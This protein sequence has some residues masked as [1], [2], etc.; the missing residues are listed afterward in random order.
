[1]SGTSVPLL[2]RDEPGR[3]QDDN[4]VAF[5][6]YHAIPAKFPEHPYDY[7]PHRPHGI[8]QLLLSDRDD[9]LGHR[10]TP[11]SRLRGEVEQMSLHTRLAYYRDLGIEHLGHACLVLR[12]CSDGRDGWLNAQQLPRAA[13]RPAGRHVR[14]LFETHDRLSELDS[15][16]ALLG[17]RLRVVDDAVVTQDTRFARGRWQAENL[18]LRLENGLPF[19]A[20]LDPPTGRLIRRLDGP[21]TLQEALAA[22]ADADATREMGLSLARRML[23]IGFLELG[24]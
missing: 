7:L 1:V 8:G 4:A 23:E 12:K 15:A 14:K 16:D 18:T 17:R 9:D 5:G 2:P 19:S 24:D 6:A 10:L 11:R 20:E 13:L 3:I 21:R 22:V